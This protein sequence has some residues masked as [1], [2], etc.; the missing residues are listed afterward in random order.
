MII[1]KLL[2]NKTASHYMKINKKVAGIMNT[3]KKRPILLYWYSEIIFAI[4]N[5][6]TKKIRK[7]EMEKLN[8]QK[9]QKYY[10]VYGEDDTLKHFKLSKNALETILKM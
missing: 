8:P 9:V 6:L 2:W 5:F 3:K 4:N 10:R 7:Y 1:L